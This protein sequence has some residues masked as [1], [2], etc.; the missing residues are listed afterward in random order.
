MPAGNSGSASAC[1][2]PGLSPV[3]VLIE[4][5]GAGQKQMILTRRS[6]CVISDV[7]CE[8][9][10]C[11]PGHLACA[12]ALFYDETPRITTSSGKPTNPAAFGSILA[13]SASPL[14]SSTRMS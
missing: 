14:Y 4:K 7:S 3:A 10:G 5:T 11:D 2:Y 9:M 8:D 12:H 6:Q 13:S 1:I